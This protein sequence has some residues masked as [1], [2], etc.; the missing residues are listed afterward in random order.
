MAA[1]HHNFFFLQQVGLTCVI[2]YIYM[3]CC[4]LAQKKKNDRA[5]FSV[6][7]YCR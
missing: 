6:S 1:T 2:T 7:Q 5:Q 4:R 3:D